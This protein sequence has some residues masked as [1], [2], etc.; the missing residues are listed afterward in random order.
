MKKKENSDQ[1]CW[2]NARLE[3]R[4]EVLTYSTFRDFWLVLTNSPT[5]TV[6]PPPGTNIKPLNT[7]KKHNKRNFRK[8]ASH[9]KPFE[10]FKL[11]KK[12][13]QSLQGEQNNGTTKPE[14]QKLNMDLVNRKNQTE[15]KLKNSIQNETVGILQD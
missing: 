12:N 10:K 11:E 4:S 5:L 7:N 8:H 2:K 6:L 15:A 9:Q 3:L 13:F 1:N 14:R